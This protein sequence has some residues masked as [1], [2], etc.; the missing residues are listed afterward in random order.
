[1][2]KHLYTLLLCLLFLPIF[3]QESITLTIDPN[4]QP[5]YIHLTINANG[6]WMIKGVKEE[7][8]LNG[9]KNYYTPISKQ[10]TITGEITTLDCSE[11]NLV[12]LSLEKATHLKKLWCFKN[13]ITSL[14]VSTHPDLIWLNCYENKLQHLTLGNNTKLQ[15][16]YCYDNELTTLDLS[17]AKNLMKIS[18]ANNQLTAIDIRELSSLRDFS[19]SQNKITELDLSKSENL[20]SLWCNSNEI[21]SLNLTTTPLLGVLDCGNNLLS[22]LDLSSLPELLFLWCNGNQLGELNLSH[23]PKISNLNCSDNL[24]SVLDLSNNKELWVLNCAGNQIKEMNLSLHLKLTD[25]LVARNKLTTLRLN[26]EDIK[27]RQIECFQNE[28]SQN[29]FSSLIGTLPPMAENTTAEI[30]LFDSQS[31]SEKNDFANAHLEALKAIGWKPFDYNGGEKKEL[32]KKED[33]FIK[34]HTNLEIGSNITLMAMNSDFTIPQMEGIVTDSKGNMTVTSQDITLKGDLHSLLASDIKI[35]SIDISHAPNLAVLFAAYNQLTT[36]DL[37]KNGKL[38]TLVL[39]N[40][41]ISHITW[42]THLAL[43]ELYLY[44]NSLAQLDLS[45][46]INLESL[47]VSNNQLT[48]LNLEE[49]RQLKELLC[50]RMQLSELNLKNNVN[51][52]LLDIS[53]NA[54]TSLSVNGLNKLKKLYLY[55]N[56]IPLASMEQLLSELPQ[57]EEKDKAL[58]MVVDSQSSLEKNQVSKEL[59]KL[60]APKNWNAYDFKGGINE[61]KGELLGNKQVIHTDSCPSFTKTKEGL[62]LYNL[63]PH[64]IVRLLSLQGEMLVATYTSLEGQ[65]SLATT[66]LPQGVYILDVN[67]HSFKITL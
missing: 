26:T 12:A 20:S 5:E 23:T 34:F 51:L 33:P 32:E 46:F 36:I 40:N 54:F 18:C 22:S 48:A 62:F 50:A 67:S 16:L 13:T 60:I 58:V 24:L 37:S 7:T 53:S 42:G 64:Q 57:R 8:V 25:V 1:M 41:Q 9:S 44:D 49:N 43:K 10:I 39:S 38:E 66:S 31:S 29:A 47:S 55:Q 11:N 56:Q 61:G 2:T 63:P 21:T 45:N 19:C 27:L 17:Q 35:T 28:L 6:E 15:R 59:L 14:D 3:S 65:C 30:V 4:E 52:E